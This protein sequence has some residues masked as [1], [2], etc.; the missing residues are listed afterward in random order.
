MFIFVCLEELMQVNHFY[1]VFFVCVCVFEQTSVDILWAAACVCVCVSALKVRSGAETSQSSTLHM[2]RRLIS[3][4][5]VLVS[6]AGHFPP[7]GPV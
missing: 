4:T 6:V 7:H 3:K 1:F 5:C 2:P